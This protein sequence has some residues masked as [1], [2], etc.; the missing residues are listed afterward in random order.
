MHHLSREWA[1][2]LLAVQF[3][4]RLPVPAARLYSADRL[5]AAPRYYPLVGALIGALGA[6][7]YLASTIFPAPIGVILSMMTTLILTGAFHED[8]LADM[9]DGIG[10]GA[11]RDNALEIMK[12]SR[13][14]TYGA[15]ALMAALGLKAAS[16]SYLPA[17]AVPILLT[18]AHGISR[19]SSV[20]T[21]ATSRYVRDH[22]T[23]KPVAS[24]ISI[25]GLLLAILTGAGLFLAMVQI[26]GPVPGIAALT[27][28]GLGHL[29]ARAVF[30]RKLGG[31]TGDCL[32]AVQQFSEIGF[33]LGALACLSS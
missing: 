16:L 4:T 20:L 12:D 14:G 25:N 15:C 27:G 24:G 30:E 31:Y 29:A 18:A 21:V 11:S 13:I 3:L 10:G 8:G 28:A 9:A 17:Q 22:G 26:V 32:G 5:A 7:V 33:Y 2:F 1:I 19:L 23:A 6:G